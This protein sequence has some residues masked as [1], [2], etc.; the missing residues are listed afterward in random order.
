MRILPISARLVK[1]LAKRN[2]KNKYK[3]QAKL[4]SLNFRHP[5]LH[6][7]RLEPKHLGVYSFR[8]NQQFRGIFFYI[9]EEN[10]IQIVDINDHYR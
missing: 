3:K 4:L 1:Y 9:P 2:L 8:I 7:E 6:V 5:S 10:A